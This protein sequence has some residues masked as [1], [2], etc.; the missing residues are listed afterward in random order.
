MR[1]RS[2][3]VRSPR[4]QVLARRRFGLIILGVLVPVTLG[5][6]LY[7]GSTLFLIVTLVVDVFLAGYIAILLSIK[8]RQKATARKWTLD[9]EEDDVRVV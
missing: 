9:P 5:L 2:T 6:A 1:T 7:T 4:E 8:Q 3:L